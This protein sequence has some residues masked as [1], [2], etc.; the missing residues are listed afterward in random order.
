MR[1]KLDENLGPAAAAVLTR[2]GYDVATV[3]GQV[4]S[5]IPD[6]QLIAACRDEA[7][8][9]VTLDSEF[10]NV[11]SFPPAEYRGIVVVR[12]RGRV[13]LPE[14]VAALKAMVAVLASGAHGTPD[15][16]LWIAEP[17]RVRVHDTG[18]AGEA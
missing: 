11:L 9:L 13:T 14:I 6:R 7:R 2:A 8:C 16:G 12:I 18:Q 4:L 1:F 3:P 17:G 10:G 15:R 5:G